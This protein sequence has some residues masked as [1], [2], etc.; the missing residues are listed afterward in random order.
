MRRFLAIAPFLAA[1]F[2]SPSSLAASDASNPCVL[3]D[4]HDFQYMGVTD[5]SGLETSGWNHE[6]TPPDLPGS[7]LSTALCAAVTRSDKGRS[8]V[9]LNL[10]S[11][12]GNV[13]TQQFDTWLKSV[14]AA[15]TKAGGTD[16]KVFKVEDTD[17][18]SGRYV[19]T[20][21]GLYEGDEDTTVV[22]HYVACDE[23]VGLV[24][25]SM[26]AQVAEGRKNELPEPA[27]VKALLDKSVA[28]MKQ[29]AFK[30]PD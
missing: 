12:K 7:S 1:L 3:L 15:D 21:P 8:A 5:E 26:N 28:R 11:V 6:N 17:C 19:T 29:T 20:I 4:W 13:T 23:H 18:E 2:V 30:T 24:H 16:I 27:Q 22:E 14:A 25:V 10:T 9:T